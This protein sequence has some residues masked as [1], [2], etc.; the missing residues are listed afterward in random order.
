MFF[1]IFQLFSLAFLL[2]FFVFVF[3]FCLSVSFYFLFF[4][5]VLYIRADQRS[6]TVGRDFINRSF[7][8]C[9][10]KLAPL[11]VAKKK[12]DKKK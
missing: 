8:V 11:M 4:S 1:F 5:E 7:R 12:T 2:I 9:K 6:V 10:V 3:C